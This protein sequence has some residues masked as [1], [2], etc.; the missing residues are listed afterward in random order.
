LRLSTQPT[1]DIASQ[2]WMKLIDLMGT[3]EILV[4]STDYPHFDF[5]D[6]DAAIPKSLPATTREKILWRN[7]AAFYELDEY[8]TI[9][10]EAAE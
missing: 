9:P 4:F 6:P 7:A 3:D 10:S 8:K 1:E 2:D 5:D